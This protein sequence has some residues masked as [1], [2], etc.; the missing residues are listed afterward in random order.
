MSFLAGSVPWTNT[1]GTEAPR[2]TALSGFSPS[3][4]ETILSIGLDRALWIDNL[5]VSMLGGIQPEPMRKVAGEA[6]D[7]GLLQRLFPIVLCNAFIGKDERH[8][9]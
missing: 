7:D 2:K 6:V 4:A 3:M 5:S 8:R 1:L 9:P